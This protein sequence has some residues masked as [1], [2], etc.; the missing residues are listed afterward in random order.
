MGS[1]LEL[2]IVSPHEPWMETVCLLML[3]ALPAKLGWFHP[4]RHIC[5]YIYTVSIYS[6]YIYIYTY[7][8]YIYIHTYTVSICIDDI[9]IYISMYT[10]YII[11]ICKTNIQYS[12]GIGVMLGIFSATL[13]PRSPGLVL[14]LQ[15]QAAGRGWDRWD[16]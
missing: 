1:S 4:T 13:D 6:K 5:I 2:L 7:S 11:Y 10:L 16:E 8:K 9:Y 3:G 14:S 15:R 12:S